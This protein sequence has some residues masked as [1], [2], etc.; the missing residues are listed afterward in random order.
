M[1]IF[2]RKNGKYSRFHHALLTVKYDNFFMKNTTMMQNMP[3]SGIVKGKSSPVSVLGLKFAI[4]KGR[5]IGGI[6]DDGS[7]AAL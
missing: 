1:S 5:R 2:K 7:G 4:E 3:C 6:G